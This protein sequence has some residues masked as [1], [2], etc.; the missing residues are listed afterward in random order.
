MGRQG[1][2]AVTR[3]ERALLAL[4]VHLRVRLQYRRDPWAAKLARR[5]GL[6]ESPPCRSASAADAPRPDAQEEP[7]ECPE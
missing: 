6:E 3:R 4:P 1:A 2:S 5:L 7:R